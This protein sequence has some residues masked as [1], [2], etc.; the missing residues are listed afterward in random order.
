M[1][2]DE[3]VTGDDTPCREDL[4]K[5]LDFIQAV[6]TRMSAASTSTKS[7]L[8]PVVTATYGYGMTQNAWSVI[9]LGL[10]AVLLFMFLDAHY[11]DREKAYRALYDA[12]A[13]NKGIPLFS[14][15]PRE[16]QRCGQVPENQ[17]DITAD[18]VDDQA[19]G[20]VDTP[21]KGPRFQFLNDWKPDTSVWKSWA[22]TPFYGSLLLVGLILLVRVCLMT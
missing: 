4:H 16:V 1:Q 12:V 20:A 21:E 8:L 13:R 19:T 22:I 15:D 2:V 7:W 10:G 17:H 14:L 3:A 18:E 5:H 11:L 6:V 9:A